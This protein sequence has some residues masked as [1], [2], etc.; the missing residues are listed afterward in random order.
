[1]D[2]RYI[3]NDKV[4]INHIIYLRYL[5]DKY[6]EKQ[7]NNSN[8]NKSLCMDALTEIDN[9]STKMPESTYLA[10]CNILK[11][12]IQTLIIGDSWRHR[13]IISFTQ[14][15]PIY[16]STIFS[17]LHTSQDIFSCNI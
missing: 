16:S 1:M 10:L 12:Y 3:R 17:G 5:Y 9:M 13:F 15:I 7:N 11:K 8:S 2:Y 4:N 6:I 14:Y